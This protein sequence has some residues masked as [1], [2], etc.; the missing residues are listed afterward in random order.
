MPNTIEKKID[1]EY[2]EMVSSGDKNVEIRLNDFEVEEGD[3]LWL[4]EYDRNDQ[5]Y[6]GREIKKKITR[7]YVVKPTTWFSIED[8]TEKGLLIIEMGEYDKSHEK[9]LDIRRREI[10]NE[11][12]MQEE[13]PGQY[14]LCRL[15]LDREILEIVGHS[16]DEVEMECLCDKLDSKSYRLK[17]E[18]FQVFSPD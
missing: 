17:G 1:P 4:R 18:F 11:K 15:N 14:V 12:N 9:F 5:I 16:C 10:Q 13:Y 3:I 8:I 2:F 7:H 6:T